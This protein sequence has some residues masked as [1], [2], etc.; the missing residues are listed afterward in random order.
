[1]VDLDRERR[2]QQH[3]SHRRS[4]AGATT[5][6]WGEQELRRQEEEPWVEAWRNRE[7]EQERLV[8]E[9]ELK[10]ELLER[11]QRRLREDGQ[12]LEQELLEERERATS[13][14]YKNF[15]LSFLYFLLICYFINKGSLE[16]LLWI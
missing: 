13:G 16:F 7:Y 3:L 5:T 6:A 9:L 4:E 11:E 14:A 8:A 10:V 15:L 12:R 1:L 2:Q